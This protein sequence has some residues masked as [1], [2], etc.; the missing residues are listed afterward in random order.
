MAVDL[1][2]HHQVQRRQPACPALGPFDQ[3]QVG[4]G[5]VR[6]AVVE[7][8]RWIAENGGEPGYVIVAKVKE[9]ANGEG[10][11]ARTGQYVDLIKDGVIDPT[12]VVRTA[13]QN[14]A[15]V[16]GMM[17]TTEAMIAE[18]PKKESGAPAGGGG[19]G[20]GGIGGMD[21]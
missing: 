9:M 7:P 13:L 17:L 2:R 18:K 6:R 12:K 21:M 8:L 10:Y 3:P 19:G 11:N 20:M 5:I 14:A 15:S 1:Q 16:A 4:A